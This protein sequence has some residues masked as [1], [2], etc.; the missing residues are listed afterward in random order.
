MDGQQR[1]TEIFAFIV[2]DEDGTEGIPA[3]KANGTM[4]PM[5]G[6]DMARID[7]LMTVARQMPGMKVSLVRFIHRETIIA[8]VNNPEVNSPE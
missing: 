1:I 3:F 2:M 7:S 8:D 5:V 6:A 4:H